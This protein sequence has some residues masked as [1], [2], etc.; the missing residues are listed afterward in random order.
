MYAL[1]F[2]TLYILY[3]NP[4]AIVVAL[5][6]ENTC[7]VLL[8]IV[9]FNFRTYVLQ[10]RDERRVCL[11]DILHLFLHGSK[12]RAHDERNVWLQLPY[13]KYQ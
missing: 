10:G 12:S 1:H 2:F 3:G 5:W 4:S 11:F 7:T 6:N 9:I 13:N 8:D